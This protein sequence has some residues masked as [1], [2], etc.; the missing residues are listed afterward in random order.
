MTHVVTESTP[1]STLSA[2]IANNLFTMF[3]ATYTYLESTHN[4]SAYYL[5]MAK[6]YVSEITKFGL[7]H[8]NK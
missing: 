1:I 8:I 2:L 3:W 4:T 6:N 5:F 7:D